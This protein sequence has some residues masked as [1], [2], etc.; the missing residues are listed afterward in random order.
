MD[1]RISQLPIPILHHILCFLS[2]KEAVR[3]CVL[4]KQWCH[5]GST[6]PNLE[7]S[8]EWFDDT[9]EKVVSVNSSTGSTRPS[10]NSSEK[11]INSTQ[12]KFVPVVDRTLQ[13]YLDQNRSK[14]HRILSCLL[15]RPWRPKGSTRPN[16]ESSEKVFNTTQQ[17][18]VSVVDRTLQGYLDQN[19]SI[20]KLHLHL[21]SPDSRPV[22][23]LPDKWIPILAALNIKAF[24]LNFLSYT[25]PYY[26]LHSAV[27]ESLEELHLRKCRL[28][29]VE[30]VR[31]KS[32]RTLTLEQVQVDGSTFDTNMLGCPLLSRLVIKS[33][34]ELRIVR[35]SEAGFKHFELCDSKRIG[36]RSIEIDVPNLETVS[37]TASWFLCHRQSALLFSRLTRLSL[38]SVILSRELFDVL[39]LSCPTLASLALDNCSGFEEFHL[40]SDSVEFLRISTTNIPPLKGVTICAP[41]ILSF[42]FNAGIPQVPDTFSVTTTT[43]KEWYSY[44]ILASSR[45]DYPDFDVNWCFCKL[46]RLLKALRRSLIS[47]ILHMDGGPLDVPC[48]AV[49][50]SHLLS[51]RPP[52]VVEDLTFSTRKCRT[53]SWYSGFTN[54]LFRV[55]RPRHIC[56]C[57][58]NRLLLNMILGKYGSFISTMPYF[59]QH[60]LEQVHVKTI[61]GKIWQ[62]VEWMNQ[63]ELRNRTYDR[64]MCLKLK[65]RD[66]KTA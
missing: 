23:S 40:A 30:S 65:W 18:F 22:V 1:D 57:R 32:L 38:N 3:T 25:P 60:Q 53:A 2:Q 28:S 6:R 58:N 59:W 41:N 37:I 35:V 26:D 50:C 24:E 64:I 10:L 8:E 16:L 9:Q 21:S 52:V 47:L 62:L 14:L 46:R 20:H 13:G 7:F 33:C 27:F 19:L 4:S 43:S 29:P 44:V 17:N 61:D 45:E 12:E 15:C 49:D 5:I 31:F 36:G 11:S 42:T 34:W 39:S 66:Q 54:G 48:S 56:G 63:S 51:N 55:C